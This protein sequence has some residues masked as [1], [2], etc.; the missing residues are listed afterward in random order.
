MMLEPERLLLRAPPF[1][2]NRQ[3]RQ[4]HRLRHQ[5]PFMLMAIIGKMEPTFGLIQEALR[6]GGHN[7]GLEISQEYKNTA[8]NSPEFWKAR[9]H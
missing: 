5:A 9:P 6:G 8:G 2:L 7:N 4:H 1:L 3:D